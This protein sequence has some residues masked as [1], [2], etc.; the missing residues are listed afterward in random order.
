VV[1]RIQEPPVKPGSRAELARDLF[2][3]SFYMCGINAVD[4]YN[5]NEKN[6]QKGRL[7]YNRSKTKGRRKDNA[8]ISI[9]IVDEAKPLFIKYLGKLNLRYANYKN[10]DSALSK[11][12]KELCTMVGIHGIT[13]YWA[14]HT[15]A[16]VARN[17]CRMSKD[18][19]ALALNHIDYGHSIT[20]SYISKDW[21][22]I[23]E[24]QINVI[25][26]F[27]KIACKLTAK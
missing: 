7:G 13:F 27:R 23:D 25:R 1:K 15:F 14:R 17:V 12:M 8:F 10:L 19:I 2:M 22:I 26:R 11:G 5:C 3:L 9:K 24:V 21:K 4:L 20:D 18:D 16:N 6:V